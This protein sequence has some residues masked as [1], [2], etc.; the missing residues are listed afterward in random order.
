MKE[1]SWRAS[2][3]SKLFIKNICKRIYQT[4]AKI[5]MS[6]KTLSTMVLDNL[7][8]CTQIMDK[9]HSIF[10]CWTFLDNKEHSDWDI[11]EDLIGND[12]IFFDFKCVSDALQNLCNGKTNTYLDFNLITLFQEIFKKTVLIIL[13]IGKGYFPQLTYLFIKLLH[14]YK[15]FCSVSPN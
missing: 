4:W 6:N 3:I 1:I 9:V 8:K 15:E 10:K 14:S 5:M 7:N 11:Y 13:N 12:K 2:N